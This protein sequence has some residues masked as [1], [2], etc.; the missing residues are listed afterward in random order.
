MTAGKF[1]GINAI[2]DERGIIAALA[3]DQRGSLR[4][5]IAKM[6]GEGDQPTAD[7]LRTFKTAVAKT[8]T[9]H[10]SAILIDP[11]YGLEAI[12]D[13]APNTGVLLA[14]EQSGYDT[15]VKGRLPDL[16]PEWSVRRL[17]EAGAHAVKVLLYYN[18][19]DE[20]RINAI[21]Q[22]YVERVGA[23]CV[24][25]DV[26]LFLEPVVYD[27]DLGDAKGPAFAKK[28]PEYVTRTMAE[29]SRPNYSV[30]VLK[31]EV[32]VNMAFV[33]DTAAFA[34]G[35]VIYTRQEAMEYFRQAA[36]VA[37]KPFIYL[38]AG[39]TDD[40]FRESLELAAEAGAKF[41]GVLCGR[42]TWQEGIPI[43]AQQSVAALED[44]LADRGVENITKLNNV[45]AQT[46][47]P[48]WTVY[49]GYEQID[50]G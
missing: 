12:A 21:K 24:A 1:S 5:A 35:E 45:L 46:A 6:R 19:F 4:K 7:D 41:S 11:E 34:G 33:K 26:P 30:D 8:L 42:A 47:Q 20:A 32:P 22:A 50:L 36:S 17:V 16:L 23:E 48:W 3:M 38:S 49:G 40:V 14:Y 2:A 13:R 9:R 29:F 18:P 31:V 37:T 44:W 25:L 27:D 15:S 28:K 39:V 43:Y 10:A